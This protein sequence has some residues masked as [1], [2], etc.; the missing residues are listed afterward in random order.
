MSSKDIDHL[1]V[2]KEA[3]SKGGDYADL[4]IEKSALTAVQIDGERVERAQ[5]GIDSGAG[6]RVLDG[7]H[8]LYAS[9]TEIAQQPF[10]KLAGQLADAIGSSA[11]GFSSTLQEKT[12]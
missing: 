1:K 12:H 5:M 6:L 7:E 4:F 3:L 8:T 2:L 11:K 9:T 10:L